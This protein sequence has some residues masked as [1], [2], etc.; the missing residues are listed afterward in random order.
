MIGKYGRRARL[1]EI[2]N[3]Q[4]LLN[5]MNYY[6]IEKALV[7]HSISGYV[8]DSGDSVPILGNQM[9]ANEV[10]GHDRLFAAWSVIPDRHNK[11]I[12]KENLR[13]HKVRAIRLFPGGEGTDGY[14]VITDWVIGDLFEKLERLRL[15]VILQTG[16]GG[17]SFEYFPSWYWDKIREI[18]KKHSDAPIVLTRLSHS[19]VKMIHEI[20]NQKL[21]NV[22]L[23]LSSYH[24]MNAIEDIVSK[25]GAEKLLFGTW[26]P[27]QDP[28]QS[29]AAITYAD[30]SLKDK[31]MIAAGN[32]EKLIE[33][34]EV[35]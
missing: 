20:F 11:E 6:G 23:D 27:F 5:K 22:F 29:I 26:M 32:L 31:E 9:M 34:V 14:Y 3:A 16:T 2:N 28:G 4:E 30:I 13:R 35:E 19:D 25:Y 8:G 33:G 17:T 24:T 18:S 12:A 7:S 10:R 21:D 15:P 1:A